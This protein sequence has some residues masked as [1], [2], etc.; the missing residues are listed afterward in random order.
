M[1]IMEVLRC[2]EIVSGY[3]HYPDPSESPRD[4]RTKKEKGRL[5]DRV[6]GTIK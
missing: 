5:T 4:E 2:L 6:S 1:W 3:V